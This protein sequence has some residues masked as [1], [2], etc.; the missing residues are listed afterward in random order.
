MSSDSEPPVI[1]KYAF[2]YY[3]PPDDDSYPSTGTSSPWPSDEAFLDNYYPSMIDEI[4]RLEEE[5]NLPKAKDEV[6]T[7]QVQCGNCWNN[8]RVPISTI[9]TVVKLCPACYMGKPS[10]QVRTVKAIEVSRCR[11]NGPVNITL[12]T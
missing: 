4:K 2:N 3:V 5:A 12:Q 8:F 11:W 1:R 7:I 6:D 9:E 10:R